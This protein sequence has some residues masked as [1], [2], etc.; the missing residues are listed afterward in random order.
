[1]NRIIFI[2]LL[3]LA[4]ATGVCGTSAAAQ[5][6]EELYDAYINPEAQAIL[7]R[8]D[9]AEKSAQEAESAART[10]KMLALSVALLIGLISPVMIARRIIVKKTWRM[11]PFGSV[12]ALGMGFL[13][14][15]VLFALNYGIFLLKIRMGN[16]FN[17]TLAF[18]LVAAMIVGSIYLL[19]K[20]D[21]NSGNP[22]F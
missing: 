8:F 10:R 14:G 7:D 22:F 11:S 16:A 21:D 18:L 1:M 20:K 13:G 5:T 15:A 17:I 2:L 12:M 4:A 19:N 6:P 3:L 9:A